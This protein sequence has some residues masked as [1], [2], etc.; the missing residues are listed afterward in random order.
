MDSL[1]PQYRVREQVGTSDPD[2]E[3]RKERELVWVNYP[4]GIGGF[5]GK[6]DQEI[7]KEERVN[8]ARRRRNVASRN[9]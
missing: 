1:L 9:T 2:P 5:W 4:N 6:T 8:N 3:P 7:E